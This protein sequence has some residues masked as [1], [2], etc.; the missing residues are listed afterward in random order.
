MKQVALVAVNHLAS[1]HIPHPMKTHGHRQ[2][3]LLPLG[4][5]P[6]DLFF[7]YNGNWMCECVVT[8]SGCSFTVGEIV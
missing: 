7:V 3:P 4:V 5:C 6:L 8:G 2:L 1:L